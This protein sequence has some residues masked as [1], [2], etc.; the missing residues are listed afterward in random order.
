MR[1][2]MRKG[3]PHS[4]DIAYARIRQTPHGAHDHRRMTGDFSRMLKHGKRRECAD[5]EAAVTRGC[6]L[7]EAGAEL[8]QAHETPRPEDA[9]FHHQHQCR[10]AGNGAHV[11]IIRVD[12]GNGL[13]ERSRL[14][15][16]ERGH[17]VA[18]APPGAK[19]ATI[20]SPNCRSISL[21]FALSTDCP[22]LPSFPVMVA[23]I[24][25]R[26]RVP[27]LSS[28]SLVVAVAVSRPTTPIG[29]PS[30]LASIVSGGETRLISTVTLKVNRM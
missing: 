25:Y 16:L 15:K 6:N 10:A 19:A 5:G 22:M 17:T 29:M 28:E 27:P 26:I 13:L 24:A 9:G 14:R 1:V 11:R 23:S 12:E 4:R 8:A 2:G 7:R 3:S 30:T 21:A 20:R 18:L